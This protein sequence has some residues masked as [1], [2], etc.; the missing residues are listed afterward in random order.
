MNCWQYK[1]IHNFESEF[2]IESESTM[3]LKSSLFR[4]NT[5]K[6]MYTH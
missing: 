6:Y 5:N 4:E 1:S 3:N 2:S